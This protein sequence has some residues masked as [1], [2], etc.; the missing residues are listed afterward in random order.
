MKIINE[1]PMDKYVSGICLD[2][3]FKYT[4]EDIK[5]P[6]LTGIADLTDRIKTGLQHIRTEFPEIYAKASLFAEDNDGNYGIF[7]TYQKDNL[8]ES[9]QV[10]LK[11]SAIRF[12][13]I[14][15]FANVITTDT[16]PD[17]L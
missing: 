6:E 12:S 14:V 5:L 2:Y 17:K 1:L 16:L 10:Y 8:S 11:E 7:L 9:E 3:S 4:D 13:N 15:G